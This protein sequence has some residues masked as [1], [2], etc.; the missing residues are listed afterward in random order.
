M[1]PEH[2]IEQFL[3]RRTPTWL[4]R[5][6]PSLPHDDTGRY[7]R[8]AWKYCIILLILYSVAFIGLRNVT[9]DAWLGG[10]QWEY[11]AMAVNF[12]HGMGLK[13]G[14]ILPFDQYKF[15]TL[16]KD[17]KR[18]KRYKEK[19]LADGEKGGR[20]NFY[21]TPG[22]PVF[23]GTL[24]KLMGVHPG[25]AKRIQL[26]L[27]VLVAAS[28]PALGNALGGR[29]GFYAGLLGGFLFLAMKSYMGNR[30]LTEALMS[31]SL[32]LSLLLWLAFNKHKESIPLAFGFGLSLTWLLLVKGAFIFIPLLFYLYMFLETFFRKHYKR[33]IFYICLASFVLTLLPYSIYASFNAYS[34]VLLSSQSKV[35][36]LDGNNEY[37]LHSGKW[38]KEW[39][40]NENSFYNKLIKET[41]NDS[42]LFLLKEFYS[43]H[44]KDIPLIIRNKLHDGFRKDFMLEI[45][46]ILL[47][48]TNVFVFFRKN[49]KALGLFAV[50]S[51]AGYFVLFYFLRSFFVTGL[52][53]FL[54][55]L[56]LYALD[57]SILARASSFW[58]NPALM[59]IFLTIL[60][61][62]AITILLFGDLRFLLPVNFIFYPLVFYM[63]FTLAKIVLRAREQRLNTTS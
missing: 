57:G 16:D 12:A 4:A 10:D 35:V 45:F 25:W 13:M 30:I 1:N 61:F 44:Y 51:V 34:V 59:G 14:G 17:E 8:G 63:L 18:F 58:K 2:A 7:Y 60:N 6:F 43:K 29:R 48:L 37:S 50:L 52:L 47:F 41:G 19:F 42:T 5:I 15:S 33:K 11:Q 22:Y 28:L 38:N 39:R 3:S 23:L 9:D 31:F 62:F 21:R 46:V 40:T 24:Y 26:F 54:G 55:T 20:D 36:I 49:Y 32:F 53:L 56:P 27:L